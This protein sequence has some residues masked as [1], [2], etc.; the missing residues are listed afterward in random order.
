MTLQSGN[1]M[2]SVCMITYNHEHFIRQAI[3]GV[4]M[5][6]TSFPIELVIGEDCSTDRTRE[7]CIEYQQKHPDKIRLLLNEKN[8]GMNPNFMATLKACTGKYIALC[9]G[10][11]YW[12]DPLKLQ[13]QVEFLEA[14][15]E[16]VICAH[17]VWVKTNGE[18]KDDFIIKKRFPKTTFNVFD[19]LF[20]GNQIHTPSVVIRNDLSDY[21]EQALKSPLGDF[22]LWVW[23]T[24]EGGLIKKF[25]EK[26][27]VYRH[28]VGVFSNLVGQQKS[29]MIKRTLELL[30]EADL[31]PEISQILIAKFAIPFLKDEEFQKQI[32]D[33]TDPINNPKFLVKRVKIG[34]LL[35]ALFL[36]FESRF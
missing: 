14:N 30:L 25:E 21:P 24:R 10:D 6:Q 3:E 26:M 12:T 9:E 28:G 27:G 32:L 35:K 16:Y 7:I 13:K 11:D 5:Q 8:L 22:F 18:L 17:D 19:L 33:G 1:I 29:E 31:S 23:L 20:F 4:L 36:K 15:K 34:N 2:A